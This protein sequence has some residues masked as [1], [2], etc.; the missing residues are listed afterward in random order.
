M[1]IDVKIAVPLCLTQL[2]AYEPEDIDQET[3]GYF[4][5]IYKLEK[6]FSTDGPARD[7]LLEVSRSELNR[8]TGVGQ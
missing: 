1:T 6:S 5:S 7:L 3:D 4:R 2:G 8:E